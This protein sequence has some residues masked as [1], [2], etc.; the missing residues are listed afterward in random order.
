MSY[1]VQG[2]PTEVVS[3]GRA[4]FLQEEPARGR[5]VTRAGK[6]RGWLVSGTW[7]SHP[8][9]RSLHLAQRRPESGI[10]TEASRRA[11]ALAGESMA[12]H[13]SAQVRPGRSEVVPSPHSPNVDG[14]FFFRFQDDPAILH[15]C[16]RGTVH[17]QGL[18]P[19]KR[20]QRG[21]P[22][23]CVGTHVWTSYGRPGHSASTVSWS[24]VNYAPSDLV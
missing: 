20:Y 3:E 7:T 10:P 6:G 2:S 23:G 24:P 14:A 9:L 4:G 1:R 8:L 22:L 17:L 15:G 16:F 12:A 13:L 19:S 11:A 21:G 18:T 5:D